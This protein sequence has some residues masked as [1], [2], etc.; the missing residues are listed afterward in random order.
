MRIAYVI[1][2]ADDIGGAQIHVRDLA[3]QLREDGHEATVLAGAR[4]PLSEQL[5]R[6]DVPF[7]EIPSLLRPIRPLRDLRAFFELRRA[8][9]RLRPDLV[10]THSS[11]AGLLGR[12]AARSLGIP[13]LFTAHGWAFTDGVDRVSRVLYRALE[14]AAVPLTDRIVT[15][16]RHD[17]ALAGQLGNAAVRKTRVI[18]N[19]MHDIPETLLADASGE[20]ARLVM[21]ARFGDQKDHATLLRA[22]AELDAPGW[23]L[24]LIGSGPLLAKTR[25]LAQRL[26]LTERV[27]FV[28]V[29]HD[30]SARL[31]RAHTFVLATHWE[32]FPRSIIEAMRAGL[33]VVASDVGGISESVEDGVTGFLVPAGD[34]SRL[35]DRLRKI[36]DSPA[37][38]HE[39]GSASRRRYEQHFRFERMYGE[40]VGVYEEVLAKPSARRRG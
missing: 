25:E 35:L 20:P 32:G 39:L 2:R 10:S 11:K 26:G 28:G 24:E 9:G 18:H 22:L 16:S 27:D 21:V 38:R 17:G 36:V 29:R 3:R 1:T 4:G 33:P 7:E 34:V 37:V 19:G 14:R 15:V 8:L 13:T 23:Q 6:L 12:A 40:T 30:V 31:A 5:E